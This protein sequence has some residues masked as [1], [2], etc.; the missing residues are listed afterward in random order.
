LK[1]GED[2][3]ASM[4]TRIHTRLRNMC[5]GQGL[6]PVGFVS[7]ETVLN[8]PIGW[9]H[10]IFDFI[11]EGEREYNP[12]TASPRLGALIVD[13]K[14][15]IVSIEILFRGADQYTIGARTLATLKHKSQVTCDVCGEFGYENI[16]LAETLQ[17][18]DVRRIRCEQHWDFDISDPNYIPEM[19]RCFG[20]IMRAINRRGHAGQISQAAA[21]LHQEVER[22]ELYLV[23]PED[24]GPF[25]MTPLEAWY[26]A[27]GWSVKPAG[28]ITPEQR[29]LLPGRV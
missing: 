21:D 8:F 29:D 15:A 6:S 18:E 1:A 26:F 4:T 20:A 7:G 16:Q 13:Q 24:A 27:Q 2:L 11:A 19:E 25:P 5:R 14:L 3:F 28:G 10:V 17:A 9:S 12:E 23:W 22:E